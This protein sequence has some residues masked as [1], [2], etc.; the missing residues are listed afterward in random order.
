M[1]EAHEKTRIRQLEDAAAH[2]EHKYANARQYNRNLEVRI[3]QLEAALTKIAN[4][5]NPGFGCREIARAALETRAE[6]LFMGWDLAVGPDKTVWNCSECGI[7]TAPC[8]HYKAKTK[9]E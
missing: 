2:W 5:A 9:G 6:P 8:K 4:A 7:G 1:S 3:E